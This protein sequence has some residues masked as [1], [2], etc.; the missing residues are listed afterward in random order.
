M[1]I[2]THIFDI[3]FDFDRMNFLKKKTKNIVLLKIK[4]ILGKSIFFRA[5]KLIFVIAYFVDSI[6]LLKAIKSIN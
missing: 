5:P 4:N 3:N 2:K 1:T 6:Y